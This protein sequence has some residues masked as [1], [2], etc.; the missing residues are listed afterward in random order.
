ML[1]PTYTYFF[2][3]TGYTSMKLLCRVQWRM[4]LRVG[5]RVRTPYCV[6]SIITLQYYV[7]RIINKLMWWICFLCICDIF[8]HLCIFLLTLLLLL[9]HQILLPIEFKLPPIEFE[10]ATLSISHTHR[11]LHDILF[12]YTYIRSPT[13]IFPCYTLL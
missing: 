13:V 4:L 11:M 7:C 2:S 9:L 10:H 6:V 5:T 1:L 12:I 8:S 3:P